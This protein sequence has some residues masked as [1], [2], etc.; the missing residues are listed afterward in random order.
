MSDFFIGWTYGIDEARKEEL[1]Q[2]EWCG[3]VYVVSNGVRYDVEFISIDRLALDAG[4]A[5]RDIGYYATG[6]DTFVIDNFSYD[7]IIRVLEGLGVKGYFD[8]K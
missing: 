6:K 4:T 3:D 2:K 8:G 5:I 1:A 7:E